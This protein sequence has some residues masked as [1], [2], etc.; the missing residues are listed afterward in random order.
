MCWNHVCAPRPAHT[1]PFLSRL[2]PRSQPTQ[3]KAKRPPLCI[4]FQGQLPTLLSPGLSSQTLVHGPGQAGPPLLTH[5]T[6]TA[7]TAEDKEGPGNLP[8]KYRAGQ[9]QDQ[10]S[11]LSVC[12][13]DS[14]LTSPGVATHRKNLR[15]SRRHP[16]QDLQGTVE[17]TC[18]GSQHRTLSPPNT[19]PSSLAASL[20]D[21]EPVLSPVPGSPVS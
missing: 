1:V 7:V 2:P 18:G 3:L 14:T 8:W 13:G 9:R 11:G 10:T 17:E 5:T 20:C 21:I 15:S 6:S 19:S 16:D 12:P 4:Q